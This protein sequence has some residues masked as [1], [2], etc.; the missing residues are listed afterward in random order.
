M[1]DA[2]VALINQ[3]FHAESV[4]PSQ[5]D[6]LLAG[7]W[8]HFGTHFFRYSYGFVEFDVR[9]VIPL[10]IRLENFSLSKSQ[11][12]ALRKNIDLDTVFRPINVTPEVESLF[13]IHKRRFKYGVPDSIFD[14]L[15]TQPATTPAEGMEAAVYKSEKLIAL[16]YFDVGSRANS[17]IYAMFDPEESAR[18]LGI[19]TMLREIE[20]AIENGK[21]FYYQGYS[22]EGNSFY[23]YK[24]RFRG[25]E[26]FDWNGTWRPFEPVATSD[27]TS[28]QSA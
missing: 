26:A 3:E 4:T 9:R 25:T 27:S 20:F 8:R 18:S 14:F 5:L 22:Y 24:K 6:A 17:G 10:R 1:Y 16:S 2:E 15:S 23:D 28:H 7:G 11:R 19:F 13:E 12:R 21:E